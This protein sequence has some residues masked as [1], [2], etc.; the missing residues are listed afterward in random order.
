MAFIGGA[1]RGAGASTDTVDDP[2]T[3][4][5]LKWFS[6]NI[7]PDDPSDSNYQIGWSGREVL[8]PWGTYRVYYRTY[9]PV[10]L[11]TEAKAALGTETPDMATYL[12]DT[13]IKGTDALGRPKYHDAESGWRH[14]E[15]GDEIEDVTA[16]VENGERK[17]RGWDT[18]TTDENNQQTKRLYDLDFDQEYVVVIVGV[19]KAGNEG[20]VTASSWTTNNTIKFSITRGWHVP[21]TEAETAFGAANTTHLTND[22]VS[23]L[24]W[25]AAGLHEV[26]TTNEVVIDEET[27]Q[28]VTTNWTGSVT[29]DY[30]MLSW[31]A[32]SFRESPDND[33]KLIGSVRSDWFVDDG[34]PTNRGSI[35][36]YRASYKDRW[37][38]SLSVTNAGQVTT[39]SQTPLVSEEVYAQTAI[40]LRPGPNFVALHGLP[41]TNT[42]RGV[43]GGTETFPGGESESKQGTGIDFYPAVTTNK[44][45]STEHYWLREDGEWFRYGDSDPVT[46]VL[47]TNGFFSRAFSI[48]LPDTIPAG[49]P[50][51]TQDVRHQSGRVETNVTTMLWKPIL[52]VPTN[53][54][55]GQT[56]VDI[57]QTGG[58][59]IPTNGYAQTIV[60]GEKQN[61][62]FNIAAFR[63]PVAAHPSEMNLVVP[64]AGST[65]T[66]GMTPGDPGNADQIWTIDPETRDAG[67]A[68]Y[69][70]MEGTNQVWRFAA[71]NNLVPAGYFKPNDVL[72]IMSR[73]GGEGNT[74]LWTYNPADIYTLPHRHMQAGK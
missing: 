45:F 33:W 50:T 73:N 28:E 36:F 32:R 34:G 11:E 25:T 38:R 69:C 64:V 3:Q 44:N 54:F 70:T 48:N 16:P 55:F 12:Y 68:C 40:P 29:K 19:D 63:L 58:T 18:I 23:A 49:Y 71:G 6:N 59:T 62:K 13:L 74:W 4:F 57:G 21:K 22:V 67:M 26:V 53:G 2:T 31:D 27:V 66:L 10:G 24:K 8:S 65:N 9:D 42:F 56:D 46:D 72:V 14:V 41:Y 47:Q 17:Y 30:D 43:F 60:C 1:N 61:P 20:P 39:V 37:R 7:G 5:D 52:L 15:N 35:R 51:F